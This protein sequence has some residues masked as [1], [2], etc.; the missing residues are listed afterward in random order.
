MQLTIE[1]AGGIAL[2]PGSGGVEELHAPRR[3][4]HVPGE[5]L[6]PADRDV[7]ARPRHRRRRPADARRRVAAGGGRARVRRRLPADRRPGQ[8]R[9]G[10]GRGAGPLAPP[11]ARRPRRRCSSCE[12]VERSGQLPA[13]ADAVL[14]QSLAAVGTW[15]EAGFDL[16]VAVNVSPRSLLD[17][18]FPAAVLARLASHAVPA[19]RLVLELAETLTI[20][21][22]EVVERALGELRDA[23]VRLALDDFGTGVSSLSV[24]SRIPVHQLKIDREF[25]MAVETSSEAAAVIRSTVDLGP[26]PAPHRGGRGCGERTAAAR[27]VGARLRRRPGPPVRPADARRADARRP[28]AR[29]R[30][31]SRRAG[32]RA[33]R[34][35]FGGPACRAAGR[36]GT[37]GRSLPHLPA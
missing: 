22:L 21:Q 24:L 17:P 4:G 26:Q 20:S 36:R 1:A 13:F 10:L 35:R 16:P 28:A 18:A 27:T 15:R 23:G 2:A 31:P 32:R 3:R 11:G 30:W 14:E 34:R 29:L 8:R 37:A 25:V 12:T 9:G 7:R 33:A 5:T 19:D 6:R